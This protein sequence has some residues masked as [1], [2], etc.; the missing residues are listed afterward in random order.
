MPVRWQLPESVA[1]GWLPH[2]HYVALLKYQHVLPGVQVANASTN[3]AILMLDRSSQK[4][5][6]AK[7]GG[8]DTRPPASRSRCG[9]IARGREGLLRIAVIEAR[10]SAAQ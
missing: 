3:D 4:N 2:E 1:D 7:Q 6:A 10:T 5:Q 8:K 9:G